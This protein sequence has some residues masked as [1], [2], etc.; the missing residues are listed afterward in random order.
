MKKK[1]KTRIR[2]GVFETNSSSTHSIS[3]A[4]TEKKFCTDSLPIDKDGSISI[5]PGEFGWEQKRYYDAYTKASYALTYAFATSSKEIVMLQEVIQEHTGVKDVKLC[6][7]E[8][9]YYAFGN[10]DH[11][12]IEVCEEAFK[13]KEAL[14]SFIFNPQSI[15]ITD[16]DNH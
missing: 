11:Q 15:L 4:N 7:S 14:R 2:H 5:Y 12:S 8:S 6:T 16:N 9:G 13:S 3:L 10:I 1:T